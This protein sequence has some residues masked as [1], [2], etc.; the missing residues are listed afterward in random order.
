ME[1]LL[2]VYNKISALK[3]IGKEPMEDEFAELRKAV[4]EFNK[5]AL[6]VKFDCDATNEELL[7]SIKNYMEDALARSN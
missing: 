5:N 2:E 1:R 7:E 4:I 3:L 6:T